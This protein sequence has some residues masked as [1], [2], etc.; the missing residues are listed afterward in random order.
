MPLKRELG[1]PESVGIGLGAIVGAGIFAVVG[2]AIAIARESVL[3]A[4]LIAAAMAYCN[5]MSSAWLAAMYPEAGGTY[6]YGR[7]VLNPWM[8]FSAGA[9]FLTSKLFAAGVVSAAFGQ[10]TY[11][12]FGGTA[13]YW[14]LAGV[15]LAVALNLIGIQKTGWVN[16]AIV[17]VGVGGLAFF[18]AVGRNRAWEF[19]QAST[20]DFGDALRAAPIIFFAFTGY[21]RLATLGGEVREPET[22]I[23]RAVAITLGLATLLYLGVAATVGF[24]ASDKQFRP[25]IDVAQ[26]MGIG[27]P[28]TIAAIAAT[29]GV[30]LSQLL[31]ISR[32]AF[33]MAQFGDLPKVFGRLD[34]R[35]VPWV[36]VVSSGALAAILGSAQSVAFAAFAILMYYAV[37]NLAALRE[38]SSPYRRLV[39][40][41]GLLLCLGLATLLPPESMA[42]GGGIL[43]TA[44]GL[45]WLLLR[46]RPQDDLG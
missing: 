15:T 31:G 1:L 26:Q 22:T 8:G 11:V 24:G 45:R 30:L 44:L 37:A 19:A 46:V 34:A 21:A 28:L 23:P 14:A 3:L 2:E 40:G 42:M 6:I 27:G 10:A 35:S 41:A 36:G 33:A 38:F 39:A 5:A 18:V 13:T 12:A 9:M 43:A 32:M 16:L 20:F 7:K 29:F 25:V 17:A 4:I